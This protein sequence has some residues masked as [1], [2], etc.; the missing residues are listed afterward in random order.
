MLA[1]VPRSSAAADTTL[2]RFERVSKSYPDGRRRVVV[3]EE[4][5][6]EVH[7]GEHIGVIGPR[8]AGKSTLLRLAAG[9][10][11]PDAGRIDFEGRDLARMS[12]LQRDRLLRHRIGLLASDDWRPAKGERV[13]D[14]VALPLVSDGATLHEAQRRARRKLNWAGATDYADDLAASLAMAERMRVMLARALVREPRLLLVD[15]PAVVPSVKEREALY[16]LI[17]AG[18]RE[19]KATLVVASEDSEATHGTDM[20]MWIEY[21]ELVRTGGEPAVV[22][23]FRDRRTGGMERSGS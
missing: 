5:S 13:V 21:G 15:E 23:P 8:R 17:R 9:V 18:A 10:E 22:V 7:A 4:V 19:H 16:E 6:F 2:L 14:L 12:A 1:R 20:L 11:S 3:L